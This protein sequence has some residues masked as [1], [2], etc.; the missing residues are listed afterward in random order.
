VALDWGRAA[1]GTVKTTGESVR[2]YLPHDL[3][4][5][6]A[7]GDLHRLAVGLGLMPK[8]VF[9]ETNLPTQPGPAS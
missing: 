4:V 8:V 3:P 9:A 1:G 6:L 2:L 5:G 7:A